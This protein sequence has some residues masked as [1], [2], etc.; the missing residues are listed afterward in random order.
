MSKRASVAD[1][2]QLGHFRAQVIKFG[3]SL[4]IALGDADGDIQRTLNWL[5]SEAPAHWQRVIRKL[6]EQVEQARADLRNKKLY[7][8]PLG[9]TPNTA[10]EE[11]ALRQLQQKL[12]YAQERL[13]N[14]KRWRQRLDKEVLAYRG[15]A[16][17]AANVVESTVPAA[18]GEIDRMVGALDQYTKLAAPE[19]RTGT[20]TAKAGDAPSVARP[21]DTI[22]PTDPPENEVPAD[23]ADDTD[24]DADNQERQS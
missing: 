4:R 20:G 7:K 2:D 1:I 15:I 10:V 11:K 5:E 17:R 23:T 19:A 8:T 13:V 22:A 12:E 3:E 21:T 6:H 14:T 16:R 18:V 9:T 24:T